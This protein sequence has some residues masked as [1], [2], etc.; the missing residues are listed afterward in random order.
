M[1]MYENWEDLKSECYKCR[2]CELCQTRTNLVFGIGN[3][4][5][6]V[7]FIGEGPGE[8]EDLKGE[9]FVNDDGVP[10]VELA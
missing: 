8:Q 9:P 7:M 6:E 3:P 2:K 1:K 4:N 5:A 10:V